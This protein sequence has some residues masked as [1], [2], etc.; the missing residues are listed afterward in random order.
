MGVSQVGG[1]VAG[2]QILPLDRSGGYHD[3]RLAM[4]Q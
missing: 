1:L 3:G 4:I 2:C